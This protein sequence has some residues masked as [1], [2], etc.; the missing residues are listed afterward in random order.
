MLYARCSL[1]T[2]YLLHPPTPYSL[3]T[4]HLPPLTPCSLPT[5]YLLPP[6]L[7][8]PRSLSAPPSH[9]IFTAHS[10]SDSPYSMFTPHSLSS[11]S[12]PCSLPAHYMLLKATARYFYDTFAYEICVFLWDICT[13]LGFRS[14][15]Y[16]STKLLNLSVLIVLL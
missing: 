15:G 4:H 1:L 10:L 5:H 8:T 3:R 13:S 16:T 2:H 14:M 12:T 11:P 7:F 6:L 9:S